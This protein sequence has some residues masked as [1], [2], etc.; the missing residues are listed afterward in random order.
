MVYEWQADSS[1][2]FS[3]VS[4]NAFLISAAL[5]LPVVYLLRLVMSK[6]AAFDLSGPLAWWNL[7]LSLASG[8]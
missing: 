5:Y 2:A 1:A 4:V 7:F 6:R 3:V 8:K